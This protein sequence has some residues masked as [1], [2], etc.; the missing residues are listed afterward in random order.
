LTGLA[1]RRSCEETLNAE[2]ARAERFASPLAI[3]VADL[4]DFKDVNDHFGHQAGDVVLRELSAV[5]R[6][7]VRDIDLTG[8]WGGEEFGLVLPGTA[9]E[10]A[11]AVAE[12]VRRTLEER[13]ML[14]VDGEPIAVT[15]SFGV[16]AYPRNGDHSS[17]V[18]AA[19]EALY[20]AK[21]DGRDRVAAAVDAASR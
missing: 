15:A 19:D 7:S 13:L 1:N 18:A 17:L 11:A 16:A 21:R 8:R 20:W 14:S 9:A 3:V 12:R 6:E 4:D 5:L 10:G 2:L